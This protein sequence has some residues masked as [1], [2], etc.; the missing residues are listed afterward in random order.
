M[1]VRGQLCVAV[2]K[3]CWNLTRRGKYR[4][5]R[6]RM[7]CF[8]VQSLVI[9]LRHRENMKR[10]EWGIEQAE[11][12]AEKGLSI[13]RLVWRYKVEERCVEKLLQRLDKHVSFQNVGRSTKTN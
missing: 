5:D 10:Q 1:S 6:T 2:L 13:D 12:S 4:P 3:R 8:A 9:R 7:D 11:D